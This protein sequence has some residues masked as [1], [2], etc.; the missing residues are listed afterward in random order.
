VITNPKYSADNVGIGIFQAASQQS[1]SQDCGGGGCLS[2]G[3]G[4]CPARAC[5]EVLTWKLEDASNE[6]DEDVV[7]GDT[8]IGCRVGK[9][10]MSGRAEEPNLGGTRGIIST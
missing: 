9:A 5:C 3:E 7:L 6:S 4:G 8:L 1:T 10:G 2:A